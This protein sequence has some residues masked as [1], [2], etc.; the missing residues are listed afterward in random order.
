M[1]YRVA[2]LSWQR[3]NPEGTAIMAAISTDDFLGPKQVSIFPVDINNR[4]EFLKNMIRADQQNNEV[5]DKD[6]ID[7][8][9]ALRAFREEV[10][11]RTG[12]SFDG[13]TVV[14]DESFIDYTEEYAIEIGLVA[15]SVSS[16]VDWERF[17]NAYKNDGWTALD[18]GDDLVYVKA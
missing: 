1:S 10:E 3:D 2:T 16:Y 4:I 7:E 15:E 18:F 17:A 8:C 9:D 13:A 12:G 11:S 5:P 14:P 6:D